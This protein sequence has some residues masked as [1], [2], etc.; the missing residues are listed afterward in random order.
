MSVLKVALL[1]GLGG[2][3]LRAGV[4]M[5]LPNERLQAKATIQ[6][7]HAV[8]VEAPRGEILARDGEVLATT[9]EMPSLHADPSLLDPGAIPALARDLAEILQKDEARLLSQLSRSSRQDVTLSRQLSPQKLE[10]VRGL[11]PRGVL[12]SRSVSTR[13]Y[14][15]RHFAAQLLGVVG[16]QGRGLEGVELALDGYLRGDTFMYIQERDRQGRAISTAPGIRQMAKPGDTVQ[17]SI[18]RGVQQ[19][20]ELALDDLVERSEP[21]SASAVVVDVKTGEILAIANRPTTNPNDRVNREISALKNHAA[22][23]AHEPG[24]VLKPFIVALAMEKGLVNEAT[25]VDCENG[26]WLVGRIPIHDDHKHKVVRLSEVIKFSSNIG[27]A[28]MAFQLGAESTIEGLKA[29][30]F[31]EKTGMKLPAEVNGF[32]REVGKIKPIEL[33]TTAFGQGMTATTLQMASAYAV[34]GNEGMRMRPYL[35][36][37]IRDHAGNLQLQNGPRQLG[38]VV[39][40]EVAKSVVRM[41][42]TVLEDGGTGTLARVPGYSAAGKTGTAQRVVAGEPGYSARERVASF[43]GLVPA[44][45]PRIA[46]AVVVDRPQSQSRFGGTVAGPAFS[47]IA[48]QSMRV[49]GIPEDRPEVGSLKP[50]KTPAPAQQINTHPVELVWADES[51]VVPDVQGLAMRDVL[52]LVNGSGLE[53]SLQGAGVA[54]EQAPAPGALLMAGDRLEVRFQ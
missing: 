42:E 11:A 48:A 41:M 43:A 14:P 21:Y 27:A 1:L 24:S 5:L 3:A 38:Q 40:K 31:A 49:L 19:A 28:K 44:S 50:V 9:V 51:L 39:S 52:A 35:V 15:G 29:F 2:L 37:E 34:L 16:H 54:I 53:L 45:N 8:T 12:W 26:R 23:D 22:V 10:E 17:L 47:M 6:F 33:A 20:A 32:L 36:D 46:I 25:W 30:G 4:L 7:Q 18:H 13:Y